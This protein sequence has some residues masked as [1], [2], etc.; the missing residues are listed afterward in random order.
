VQKQLFDLLKICTV[1]SQ[2]RSYL[3]NWFTE[4]K[5]FG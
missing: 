5:S 3:T 4:S 2:S 1:F